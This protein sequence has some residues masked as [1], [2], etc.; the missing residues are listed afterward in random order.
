MLL[1]PALTRQRKTGEVYEFGGSLVHIVE[2]GGKIDYPASSSRILDQVLKCLGD[3]CGRSK[4]FISLWPCPSWTW[5]ERES[6]KGFLRS[7]LE[8]KTKPFPDPA[9]ERT[10]TQVHLRSE[11]CCA[12][13]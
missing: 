2:S 4:V 5:R 6:L 13:W 1:T 9:M 7:A 8:L 11:S 3:F 10:G 12:S